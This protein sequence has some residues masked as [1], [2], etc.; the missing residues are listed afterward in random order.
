MQ[1]D[2][3]SETVS[4][5]HAHFSH[6]F[7]GSCVPRSCGSYQAPPHSHVT[8]TGPIDFG[9]F[10]KISCNAGFVYSNTGR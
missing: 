6:A 9:E 4:L 1:G 10:V 5:P 8:P 7:A 3:E 2:M